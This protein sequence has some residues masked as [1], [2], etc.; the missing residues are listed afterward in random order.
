MAVEERVQVQEMVAA[1]VVV[2]IPVSPV[3]FVPD[4]L[5]LGEGGRL[6]AVHGC[7][8]VLVHPLAVAG[9]VGLDAQGLVEQ[10]VSG[11][12]DVHEVA[13]RAW[14]VVLPIEVDVDAAGAVG[15]G[16]GFA[17][18]PD[19]L[20]QVLDVLFVGED[21]ADQLNAVQA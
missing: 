9:P 2:S 1:F 7:H 8:K 11:M 5:D 12:D 10:V 21:R 4:A 17:Q 19:D 16:S 18:R 13:D 6:G 3:A 14:C 20:L 15:E